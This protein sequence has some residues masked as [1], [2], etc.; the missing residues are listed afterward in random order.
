MSQEAKLAAPHRS[1]RLLLVALVLV[2]LVARLALAFIMD[3]DRATR[4]P[5]SAAYLAIGRS[6]AAGHGF[7]LPEDAAEG[8]KLAH[9]MP[10]YPLILAA[11]QVRGE[12][13]IRAVL[14]LQAIA[15]V[16]TLMLVAWAASRLAGQWAAVVAAAML[17]FDPFQVYFS[18]QVV[19]VTVLGLALAAVMLAGVKC[20]EAVEAGRRSAW[21]WAALG[22]LALAAA[23]YLEAWTVGL[24]VPAAV[25]ALVSKRRKRLL[26]GWAVATAVLVLALAPWL[27]RNASS[28]G[29]PTLTVD[30]ARAGRLWSPGRM[31][32]GDDGPL[33][34]VAGYTSLLPTAALAV[35]GLAALRRRAAGLWLLL[36]P[37]YVTLVHVVLPGPG[38]DRLVVMP[39]LAVLAGVGLVALLG[40]GQGTARPVAAAADV[41][42]G[43]R[44]SPA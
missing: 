12:T 42:Q 41:S 21:L 6:V 30:L 14:I 9:C 28:I 3:D 20:L 16:E 27:V 39:S 1:V 10:G 26:A 43:E 4:L 24:I 25:A 7:V 37:V 8:R 22:G 38:S 5:E 15:A 40:R 32:A 11:A 29:T 33:R 13:S 19:P 35:A 34:P 36:A 31:L 2:G 18:A 17:T 44:R 23:A